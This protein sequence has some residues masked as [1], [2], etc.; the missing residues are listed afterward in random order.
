M[1][2]E[3]EVLKDTTLPCL[4][5]GTDSRRSVIIMGWPGA[6][7]TSSLWGTSGGNTNDSPH[8]NN[9]TTDSAA[10]NEKGIE[11]KRC[12]FPVEMNN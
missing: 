5:T 6:G 12:R 9:E 10:V 3:Y 11:R 1:M 4:L 2:P 7:A 8:P